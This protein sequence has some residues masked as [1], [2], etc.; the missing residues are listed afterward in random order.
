MGVDPKGQKGGILLP[1]N[2]EV[3][4]ITDGTCF[5]KSEV[6]INALESRSKEEGQAMGIVQRPSRRDLGGNFHKSPKR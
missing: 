5:C 1:P 2:G 6:A 4:N 3:Q